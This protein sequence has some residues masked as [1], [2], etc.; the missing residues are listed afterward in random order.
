MDEDTLRQALARVADP[1][2]G[3]SIVALGLVDRIDIAPGQVRVTLIPTSATCPM[4]ELMI[5]EAEQA[6]R[7]VCPPATQGEVL[8]DGDRQWTPERMAEPLRRSFGW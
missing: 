6:V 7:A 1:E 5:E 2:I 3:H 8:I 4:S